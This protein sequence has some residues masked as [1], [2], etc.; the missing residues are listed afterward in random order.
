MTTPD[1]HAANVAAF[2]SKYDM[3]K[4]TPGYEPQGLSISDSLALANQKVNQVTPGIGKVWLDGR[5]LNYIPPV[6]NDVAQPKPDMRA[7]QTPKCDTPGCRG[8]GDYKVFSGKFDDPNDDGMGDLLPPGAAA[9]GVRVGFQ[10]PTGERNAC[11]ECYLR[12]IS[13]NA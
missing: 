11:F 9:A 7:P 4:P 2:G 12:A 8:E 13:G 10:V 6:S 1:N 3:N 5:E